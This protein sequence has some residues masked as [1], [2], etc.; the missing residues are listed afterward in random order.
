MGFFLVSVVCV[1]FNV[2]KILN[3]FIFT[4]GKGSLMKFFFLNL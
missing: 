4:F 1:F 2:C 3:V